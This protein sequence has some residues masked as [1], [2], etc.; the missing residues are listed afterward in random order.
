VSPFDRLHPAVQ[1]HV[2]NSLGWH[3]LR[4][5]QEQAIEPL[6]DG[7]HAILV[8]PTAGGKT[9]AAFLPILSR[10]L[11][12][13]WTGL[14][15]IYAC[16]LR[17][18]INDL[19]VRL[20]RYATL[21]G[22]RVAMWHGD[23][24]DAARRRIAADPP[25][26]LLTTPESIE[27][28]LVSGRTDHRR[29][30]GDIRVVIIDELHAFAGDDRGWHLLSGLERVSRLAGRELQ[31]IG[32]SATIGN[33]AELLRWLAGS[34][35]GS[36][37]VVQPPAGPAGEADVTVDHVGHLTNAATVISRLHA[38]E[39]R[40]VFCDSRARVEEL[41]SKLRQTGT[42]T[43]V[44][45]SSLSADERRRAERAFSSGSNCVIVATSTLELGIDVGDLDRVIQ[46]D[47]PGRVASVL[48]RLGR[49]GRRPGTRSNCLFLTT[50]DDALLLA[51]GLVSLWA[52][53]YVEPVAPPPAPHHIFA[54]QLMGLALQESGIGRQD[55]QAWLGKM[56][57]FAEMSSEL[58]D[59]ILQHMLSEGILWEDG[60]VLGLGR[61]GEEAFGHRHFMALFS[62]F[63]SE[64]LFAVMHGRTE[65]G[66][67]HQTSFTVQRDEPAAVLLA[68]RSWRVTHVD[69]R[70]RV[71]YVEPAADVGRSRWVGSGQPL[72]YE[73]C[74][75]I[76]RL[77]VAQDTPPRA[78]RRGASQLEQI[79][80]GYT[81]LP[82]EGTVVLRD[83]SDKLRWW[84][85]AG[86]LANAALARHLS[87]VA[88]A[89]CT[90]DNFALTMDDQGPD[91]D[92]AIRTL[93]DVDPDTLRP[94][95]SDDAVRELKFSECL[96]NDLARTVLGE[97]A[98]DV[99]GL[100]A[101]LAQPMRFVSVR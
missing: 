3:S 45:H 96:P 39:K 20:S 62:A 16:P 61:Q 65:L 26:C 41:A 83:G 77:L 100:R 7:D 95:V 81:W 6:L 58:T 35:S 86:Q 79:R 76:R 40:L 32:L 93:G 92:H 94:P 70:K 10:M 46:I 78:S 28:M 23:V 82:D 30:F 55:W 63:T 36:S 1:H 34:C 51:L 59:T 18:L 53:G 21:V 27:V 2:V 56:P 73:L 88:G 97:R 5:L 69:W 38:G 72:R 84:T 19:E 17:A 75:A 85:F 8:A 9:E 91:L 47:A 44:S 31:R 74:Q 80:A 57:A 98:R 101:V 42:E 50:T 52:D 48:Q 89:Q 90:A 99:A 29:L 14:S 87:D 12:E 64:P 33:P 54:Q 67:V 25:D 13:H 11:T 60:G 15:L 37:T 24:G 66:W 22:R 71:A 43:H 68:G 4:P 49:T